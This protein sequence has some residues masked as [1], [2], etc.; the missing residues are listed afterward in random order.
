MRNRRY[1][2]SI[3]DQLA[4]YYT[5]ISLARPVESKQSIVA[6]PRKLVLELGFGVQIAKVEL[7]PGPNML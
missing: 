4:Y 1:D 7:I 3:A 2:S 5:N 6:C